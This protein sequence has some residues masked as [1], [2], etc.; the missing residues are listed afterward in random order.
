MQSNEMG[1]IVIIPEQYAMLLEKMDSEQ[2]SVERCVQRVKNGQ[3]EVRETGDYALLP[4]LEHQERDKMLAS[5]AATR[6]I[7]SNYILRDEYNADTIEIGT[8]F[9][10]LLT[11][12][13]T[14]ETV[15]GILIHK[16]VADEPVDLFISCDTQLGINLKGHKVGDVVN[17]KNGR[18]ELCTAEILKIYANRL[19][20]EVIADEKTTLR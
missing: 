5:L 3:S 10:I 13:I 4:S 17:F 1:S 11:F 20:E 16:R 2:L 14:K 6:Q 9:Q 19:G 15:D 18:G 8:R 12:G 7:L